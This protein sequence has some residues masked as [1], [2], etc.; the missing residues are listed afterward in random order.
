M[1]SP[2]NSG[3]YDIRLM[4]DQT[5]QARLF[6]SLVG[7]PVASRTL[8]DTMNLTTSFISQEAQS[9]YAE[10]AAALEQ[11]N[12][13][14][15]SDAD[16]SLAAGDY[17]LERAGDAATESERLRSYYNALAE[18][19]DAEGTAAGQLGLGQVYDALGMAEEATTA[20]AKAVELDPKSF[21]ARMAL[22]RD[23]AASD[24]PATAALAEEQYQAA[25]ALDPMKVDVYLA[26]SSFYEAQAKPDEARSILKTGLTFAPADAAL[27]AALA[28]LDEG[29]KA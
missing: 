11:A 17:W 10:L 7:A 25:R 8:Y 15:G 18:Y 5:S 2:V 27:R 23:Y 28:A 6:A 14:T 13:G 12:A 26:L 21:E 4:L 24:D 3:L 16:L 29:A 20:F 1:I 9:A 19:A 22:G